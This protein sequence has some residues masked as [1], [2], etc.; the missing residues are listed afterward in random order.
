MCA[1]SLI[2]CIGVSF[3]LQFFES[4][5][6]ECEMSFGTL[7][8]VVTLFATLETRHLIQGS[9]HPFLLV[10]AV[11][12]ALILDVVSVEIEMSFTTIDGH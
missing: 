11:V 5:A 4:T 9:V 2:V 8:G 1:L 3:G 6:E 12:C 7:V 10:F